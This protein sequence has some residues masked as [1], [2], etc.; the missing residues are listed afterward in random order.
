M[1]RLELTVFRYYVIRD[2]S[3]LDFIEICIPE[4][5]RSK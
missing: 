4:I 5:L 3:L 1:F 2:M